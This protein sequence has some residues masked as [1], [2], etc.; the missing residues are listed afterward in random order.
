[1]IENKFFKGEG[2]MRKAL[3]ILLSLVVISLPVF[4]QNPGSI[5]DQVIEGSGQDESYDQQESEG[6]QQPKGFQAPP[7]GYGQGQPL[8]GRVVVAPAGSTFEATLSTG[9]SSGLNSIGDVVTATVSSPL[10]IGSNV[11]IP[12]GSQVVGQ[13]VNAISARR[14][15]AGSG[16]VLEF[17]FTSIRTPDGQRYPLSASVDTTRFKLQAETGGSR[18][19]KVVGKTAVGAGAGALAGLVGAAISGGDKSKA[20]AIGT[21]IGAGLGAGKAIIDKGSELEIPSGSTL[22]IR[23]EQALQAVVQGQ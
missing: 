4:A 23:L 8:K 11:V 7:Q 9:L 6:Y 12:A 20:A 13:V 21:G 18:T 5:Y 22:P 3:L 2:Y 14:F 19:A 17:R 15:R 1:M 16:G 10:V